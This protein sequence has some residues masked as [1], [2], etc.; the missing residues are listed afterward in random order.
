MYPHNK[1]NLFSG[2]QYKSGQQNLQSNYDSNQT[3]ALVHKAQ[4]QTHQAIIE[5]LQQEY[6]RHQR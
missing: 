3:G 5:S 6:F 2:A 1:S 4:Q